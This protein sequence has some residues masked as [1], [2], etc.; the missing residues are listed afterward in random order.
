MESVAEGIYCIDTDLYRPR[1]A[2]SYLIRGGDSLAFVDT[3]VA[4]ALPRLLDA[5]AEIGLTPEHVDMVIPT[6]VHLDHAGA[7][8]ALLQ[9][10]PN[11]RLIVHPKG[12]P[13]LID[14]AK[15]IA[16]ATAVYGAEEFE[17]HFGALT[18]IPES[19]VELA[20]DEQSLDLGGRILR[21]IDTPGH[22]NHHGCLFDE[23]TR[24]W[25]TG[26]TFGIAYPEFYTEAGPWLFAPT[27]P[28]AFDPTAWQAS[29]ERLLEVAPQMMFLTHFGRVD[30]PAALGGQLRASIATLAEVA[31]REEELGEDA[32]GQQEQAEDGRLARLKTAVADSLV[33]AAQAHGVRLEAEHIRALLAVDTELNA[34]GL[35]V[36]LKRRRKQREAAG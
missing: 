19:R 15:L 11:A 9:A 14:P 2:A 23:R 28:V 18:P 26:D 6:H 34:Q 27:T 10:C 32:S 35:D 5:V 1:L 17:R 22:A 20:Q 12:A 7:A 36:W 16:G 33:A 3:G 31:L 4:R 25:F 21:F 24:G 8:G 13:H 29:V 30:A